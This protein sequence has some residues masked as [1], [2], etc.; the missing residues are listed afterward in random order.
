[1]ER[2]NQQ[3]WKWIT[4]QKSLRIKEAT[5][6]QVKGKGT[7]AELN[8]HQRAQKATEPPQHRPLHKETAHSSAW[9]EVIQA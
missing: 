5:D 9:Y 6:P 3:H 7:Q 4:G 1:M 8:T 2:K